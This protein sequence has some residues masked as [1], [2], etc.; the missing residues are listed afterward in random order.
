[1][2][3]FLLYFVQIFMSADYD[4]PHFA[5]SKLGLHGLHNTIKWISGETRPVPV[6]DSSPDS[7]LLIY[8]KLCKTLSVTPTLMPTSK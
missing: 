5:A 8:K 6:Q 7:A 3:S 1:M 2:F 4:Q